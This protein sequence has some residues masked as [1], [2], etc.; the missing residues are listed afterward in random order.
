[1]FSWFG[2]PA[3]CSLGVFLFCSPV[4]SASSVVLETQIGFDGRFQLG[5]PF[6][7]T[8][9]L[10]GTGQPTE[11]IVEVQVWKRGGAKSIDT[12][13]VYYRK[14]VFLAAQSRKSVP[15]TIDPD[16]LSRPLKVSFSSPT[17]KASLDIDLRPHFSTQPLLLLVSSTSVPLA[18]PLPPGLTNPFITVS[19]SELPPDPRAY[20]G[21]WAVLFYEQPLRELSRA[22]MFSLETWL[23][24]GGKIVAMGGLSPSVFQDANWARLL[25]GTPTGLK[26]LPALSTLEKKYSAQIPG[27]EIW[28]HDAR[29]LQ[30]SSLVEEQGY[31][32]VV[33]SSRG[34]GRVTFLCFDVGRPPLSQWSGLA[35]L[36]GD[37]L[38][39]PPEQRVVWEG[40]WDDTFFARILSTP[41][42]IPIYASVLA[43]L[44]WGLTYGMA[45]AV[46]AKYCQKYRPRRAI[47][48]AGFFSLPVVFS[49]AGYL[50]FDRGGKPLD[51]ILVSATMLDDLGNG[52]VAAQSNVAVFSTRQRSYRLQMEPGWS[53]FEVVSL[54][55]GANK[56]SS[57]SLIGDGPASDLDFSLGEWSS[58]LFRIH[59]LARLPLR[60]QVHVHHDGLRLE[61]ANP[62][63]RA[64][65]D[66]W[67][68]TWGKG[69]FLGDIAPGSN[70]V[71]DFPRPAEEGVVKKGWREISFGDP[72]R[73]LLFHHSFF[74][75][76]NR[77]GES[78]DAAFFIGWFQGGPRGLSTTD[79]R[80]HMMNYTLF[81]AV[82]PVQREEEL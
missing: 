42:F 22:Q 61:V 56:N 79:P 54:S 14:S 12:Y 63:G 23:L 60:V 13:P 69:F 19:L 4:F 28:F 5:Q 21:V 18:L 35:R 10:A 20:R 30:G 26:K 51:G 62:S 76:Q 78:A 3:L 37:V 11:G 39:S 57:L 66:C 48:A 25:P 34:K 41:S 38:G 2:K 9:T 31:P 72:I 17:Q 7:I 59:A 27:R 55:G 67:F 80:I 73:E 81:R 6:P 43:F 58:R 75:D 49:L 33:E 44:F 53:D 40:T 50:Y 64:L 68:V 29:L 82:F 71:R 36:L 24:W 8:V 46:V 70:L 77:S 74:S 52:Y 32:M 47:V 16:F 1:M 45:L 15:F 65:N